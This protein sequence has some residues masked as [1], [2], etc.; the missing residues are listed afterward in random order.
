MK[1]L[2]YAAL[3]AALIAAC[4]NGVCATDLETSECG[5]GSGASS[6][7][8]RTL[9]DLKTLLTTPAKKEDTIEKAGIV[10][11]TTLFDIQAIPEDQLLSFL[12]LAFHATKA[13]FA[14]KGRGHILSATTLHKALGTR[15][16]RQNRLSLVLMALENGGVDFIQSKGTL[17][18]SSTEEIQANFTPDERLQMLTY[19]ANQTALRYAQKF[20]Y[21]GHRFRFPMTLG[22]ESRDLLMS[23]APS[24]TVIPAFLAEVHRTLCGHPCEAGLLDPLERGILRLLIPALKADRDNFDFS[25]WDMMKAVTL[26]SLRERMSDIAVQAMKDYKDNLLRSGMQYQTESS[27]E[28]HE[29]EKRENVIVEKYNNDP[30]RRLPIYHDERLNCEKEKAQAMEELRNSFSWGS[31]PR[32]YDRFLKEQEDQIEEQTRYRPTK[33]LLRSVAP[34]FAVNQAFVKMLHEALTSS[35]DSELKTLFLELQTALK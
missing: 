2:N 31:T 21:V 34:E 16:T 35:A 27:R 1:K 20:H 11:L 4:A 30:R 26:G 15:I 7:E 12:D 28:F 5:A 19:F 23:I 6:Y 24:L 17:S 3:V 18:V 8:V 22:D 32:Q 9:D 25:K 14:Y 33:A 29:Y 13:P 10:P